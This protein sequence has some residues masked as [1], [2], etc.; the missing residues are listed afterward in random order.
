M[1][2]LPLSG[3]FRREGRHDD[4]PH[5][6]PRDAR[7]GEHDC[8]LRRILQQRRARLGQGLGRRIPLQS[9]GQGGPRPL[10]CPRGHAVARHLQWLPADGG[11]GSHR[12]VGT[13]AHVAQRF[14]EV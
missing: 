8:V 12:Q 13:G 5:H 10:L 9:E 7:R 3:R 11:T 6:R 4:R 14:E 2:I 1:G